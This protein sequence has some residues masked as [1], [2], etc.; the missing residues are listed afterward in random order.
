LGLELIGNSTTCNR[1]AAGTRVWLS[2]P[3]ASGQPGQYREV[4]SANGFS[5]QGDRR[6]LFGL[7]DYDGPVSIDIQWCGIE[8]EQVPNLETNRYHRIP[9]SPP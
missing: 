2:F 8:R 1:D 7:G 9:Q 3:D 4:V 6:L 5:A